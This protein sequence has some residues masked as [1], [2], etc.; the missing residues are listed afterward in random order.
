VGFEAGA[1]EM[2]AIEEYSRFSPWSDVDMLEENV[3]KMLSAGLDGLQ[4]A[5]AA[6]KKYSK[7]T[8]CAAYQRIYRAVTEAH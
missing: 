6:K 1:P 3:R 8:M 7:E 4:I 2:I 5:E